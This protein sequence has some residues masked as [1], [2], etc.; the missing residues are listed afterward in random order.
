MWQ[1]IN[2]CKVSSRR[3][4]AHFWPQWKPLAHAT[5]AHRQNTNHKTESNILNIYFIMVLSTTVK[6][7]NSAENYLID[8]ENIIYTQLLFLHKNDTLFL[9]KNL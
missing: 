9:G 4:T 6:L 7:L 5:T 3:S 1:H 2:L 8:K